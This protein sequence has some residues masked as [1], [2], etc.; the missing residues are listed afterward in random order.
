MAVIC[1]SLSYSHLIELARVFSTPT[2]CVRLNNEEI[3]QVDDFVY[4]GSLITWD[5]R[6]DKE[7]RRRIAIAYTNMRKLKK[8]LTTDKYL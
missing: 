2:V 8:L 7:I 3:E 1:W 6:Q 5:G 4:L